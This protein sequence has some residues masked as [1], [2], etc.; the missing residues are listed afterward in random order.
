MASTSVLGVVMTNIQTG[1]TA[2]QWVKFAIS[3]DVKTTLKVFVVESHIGEE[4]PNH[5]AEGKLM[6]LKA[7][8]Q[9]QFQ[10]NLCM[11]IHPR[12]YQSK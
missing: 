10:A 6:N 1:Q 11:T 7:P 4:D 5:E 8:L 3:V 2:Q 12:L 9:H